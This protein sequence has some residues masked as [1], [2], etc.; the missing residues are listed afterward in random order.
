[1]LQVAT[2]QIQAGHTVL[3]L[4][5]DID[6]VNITGSSGGTINF[7]GA[8]IGAATLSPTLSS[9]STARARV[10]YALENWLFFAT[11]GFDVT[12]EKSNLT[13]PVGFLCGTAPS[14]VPRIAADELS[15]NCLA[16]GTDTGK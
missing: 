1:M 16:T 14:T 11:G 7:T 8:P 9:L 3:G 15:P 13:G 10:G 12:N 6:W 5:A 2:P 4:K